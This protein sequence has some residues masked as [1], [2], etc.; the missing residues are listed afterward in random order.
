MLYFYIDDL[1]MLGT[2]FPKIPYSEWFMVRV[3]QK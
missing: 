2:V 1:F 3:S